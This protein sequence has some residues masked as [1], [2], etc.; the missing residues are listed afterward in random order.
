MPTM[1]DVLNWVKACP[2]CC[3]ELK[4]G[5]TW[6]YWLL[7]WSHD[8]ISLS[9]RLPSVI[10]ARCTIARVLAIIQESG[11]PLGLNINIAKCELFSSRDL[12][13]F[14]EEMRRSNVPHFE[15]LGAP[16]GDLVFCAKFVAQKQSEG[17]DRD[18]NCASSSID[19]QVAL[20]LL[21][22]CGSFC[23]LVHL[24]RNT[25]PLLI[26]EAFALFDD[27][28][29]QCFSECTAVDASA[30]T[31]QQAQLSLKRGGLGLRSLSFHSSAA[32]IASFL[33]SGLSP[34]SGRYISS[35]LHLYNSLVD[36]QD[37][38]THESV[39]DSPLSQKVLSSKIEDQQFNNLFHN[40]SVTDR[41]RLLSIS[42][43]HASAWLSVTPSPRLN[44][45]LEPAEFQVA[46]K[47]W[48]GIPVVQGQ[49]CPHCP[50]CV[51]DDF[52]HHSLTCKHG[53]DVVSRHNK[54]KDVFYD[55]CKRACLGPRLELGCGAGS[56]SQSRPADVLVPNWDLG[57]P[58]AF[59]LSVTSTLQSSALLEASV[60]AGSAALFAENRKH[61]NSD[62]K[63]DELGWACI[64]LVVETYGCWGAE[65]VAALSELAGHL[66]VRNNEPKSKTIFSLYS[67]LGLNYVRRG[68]KVKVGI[69]V[70]PDVHHL[71]CSS[72]GVVINFITLGFP[73]KMAG[74][75]RHR[76]NIASAR[77]K[78]SNGNGFCR[79]FL[80]RK[81][82]GKC[83]T[84][85]NMVQ[86]ETMT[87]DS[88][89][90]T[91]KSVSPYDLSVFKGI[92]SRFTD[93]M[94]DC[95]NGLK[96][97]AQWTRQIAEDVAMRFLIDQAVKWINSNHIYLKH[98]GAVQRWPKV[99]SVLFC[100]IHLIC[101]PNVM[102]VGLQHALDYLASQVWPQ[103][104][105]EPEATVTS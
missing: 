91:L 20:L 63:C 26:N 89:S 29:Q 96:E 73:S 61:N 71:V 10:W 83:Q 56:D 48:L 95:E 82:W 62:K 37:S 105:K 23:R 97:K 21:R 69:Q 8:T 49:S 30:A 64:P 28:V 31:W 103:F 39:G 102:V 11:P 3:G 94:P 2:T 43:P 98:N 65:A 4:L 72:F 6:H 79:L 58:A 40:A 25:P 93:F 86:P 38:I 1:L 84:Y 51:L 104:I 9:R 41:A 92:L 52:G 32:Y 100:D 22:Q 34:S 78:H 67:R 16:I 57:K 59:D 50:S 76:I 75:A 66:S 17:V 19:P 60:T 5:S 47:W 45:H 35:S 70:T 54:L 53:V 24:A 74:W 88:Y 101:Q 77:L 80:S 36:P 7:A 55:F 33:S 42:S 46:L 99:S 13:S 18:E 90:L 68:V 12:S 44:L 81:D 14:P 87:V 15:I 27:C 85:A